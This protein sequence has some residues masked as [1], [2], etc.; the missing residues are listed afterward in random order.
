MPLLPFEHPDTGE[1]KE[2]YIPINEPD[3]HAFARQVDEAGVIWKRVFEVPNLAT[4]T[5]IDPFSQKDFVQKTNDKKGNMGNVFDLSAEM[6]AKR[7]E[8]TGG[9]DPVKQKFYEDW[10]KKRPGQVHPEKKKEDTNEKLK[11]FGIQVK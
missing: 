11:P 5:K 9:K 4:N 6:S 2:F 3:K 10:A 1:V 8:I 7:A